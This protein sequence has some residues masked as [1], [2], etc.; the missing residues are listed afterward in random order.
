MSRPRR[1]ALYRM[2]RNNLS[3]IKEFHVAAPAWEEK[4]IHDTGKTIHIDLLSE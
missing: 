3:E 2:L 4:N 1:H